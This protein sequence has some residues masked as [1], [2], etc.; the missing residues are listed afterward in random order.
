MEL[1]TQGYFQAEKLVTKRIDLADLVTEGF[2]TLVK[3]KPGENTGSSTT[4]ITSLL[5]PG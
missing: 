5:S 2:E 3:E 1:M 4:I